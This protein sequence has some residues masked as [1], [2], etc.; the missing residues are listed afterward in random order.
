MTT[1]YT[2]QEARTN[3]LRNNNLG[4]YA[5]SY[6]ASSS[7]FVEYYTN[8]YITYHRD[9]RAIVAVVTVF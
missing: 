6:Y 2:V 3:A 5:G 9:G 8:G 4:A 1:Y 7:Q